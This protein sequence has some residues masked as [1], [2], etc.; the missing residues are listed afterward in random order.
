MDGATTH[1]GESRNSVEAAQLGSNSCLGLRKRRVPSSENSRLYGYAFHLLPYI[2]ISLNATLP[3]IS[4]R[5][6]QV[7]PLPLK[8]LPISPEAIISVSHSPIFNP[9]S[10]L[11]RRWVLRLLRNPCLMERSNKFSSLTLMVMAWRLQ[12]VKTPSLV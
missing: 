3:T 9:F 1:G 2:S 11:S 12:A 4:L 6:H 5:V 10:I 7:P 8:T